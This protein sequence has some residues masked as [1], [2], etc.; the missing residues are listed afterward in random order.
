MAEKSPFSK[1]SHI[2]VVVRDMDTAVKRLE[3]LGIGPFEVATLP[4]GAEMFFHDKPLDAELKEFKA[5]I[6][7]IKLELFEPG[8]GESPHKEFLDSRG[9]GIHHIGFYV[10]DI[11]EVVAKLTKQ[12]AREIFAGKMQGRLGAAYLDLAVGNII[13]EFEQK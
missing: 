10:D 11:D 12:G 13:M 4:P 5:V 3:S 6:G 7:D 2:A 8:K 9:E 1:L